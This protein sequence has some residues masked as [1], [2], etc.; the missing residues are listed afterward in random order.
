MLIEDQAVNTIVSWLDCTSVDLRTPREFIMD[1]SIAL[2][3]AVCIA[4]NYSSYKEYLMTCSNF[5]TNTS[6]KLPSIFVRQDR[7]HLIHGVT[8][9]KF[10]I[11]TLDV[12]VGA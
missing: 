9:W 5:L 7:N 6:K 11:P 10:E 3:H 12:L 1:G 4:F 8:Q 2:A